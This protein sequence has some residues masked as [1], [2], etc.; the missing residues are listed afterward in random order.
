MIRVRDSTPA[1]AEVVI[2][3]INRDQP[4]PLGL[5]QMRERLK[6]H[7][8]SRDVWRMVA[9]TDDGQVVGYGH[10]LRDEW[11]ESGL[12]WIKIAVAYAARRQGIG[13]T[14]YEALLDWLRPRGATS[15]MASIYEHVPQSVQFAERH[16]FHIERHIFEST[17]DLSAFD[18]RQFIGALDTAQAAGIRFATM[19]DLGD[20]P[21]ARHKLWEVESVTARDVPG[22][23]E[24]TIRP[25]ET[26]LE[27]ICAA[28]GYRADCQIVALDGETW[29]GLAR[30]EPTD[31]TMAMYNGITGVLPAW[32]GRGIALALKLLG[33]RAARR[34]GAGY[35]RTNND[36]ENA[37]MLA[38]NRKLGYQPDP[39]Y[40]RMRANLPSA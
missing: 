40:Y 37:P 28:P 38:V 2:E 16:G 34:H 39:G 31:E 4:G 15:L 19:A 18:E 9:E 20:T 36:S 17:L 11:M 27:T 14:I 22:G 32:R 7:A 33:I 25:F 24:A 3:I 8:A 13:T 6:A 10:A 26:F 23:S 29:V 5:E 21:E 35:L 30:L 1:D 12:F